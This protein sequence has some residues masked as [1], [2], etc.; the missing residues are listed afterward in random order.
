[1]PKKD[2]GMLKSLT[3]AEELGIAE[4]MQF[5]KGNG[6]ISFEEDYFESTLPEGMTMA[7]V[8]GVQKHSAALMAATT[9]AVG[10]Q[11]AEAFEGDPDLSEVTASYKVGGDRVQ[12]V[13]TRPTEENKGIA[14]VRN[15]VDV[16]GA[17]DRGELK[18]ARKFVGDLFSNLK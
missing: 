11:A 14:P 12:V 15:I 9:V 6:V 1:M 13:M 17:G 16:Y 5:D 3:M 7:M 10:T 2:E 18:K 4:K 8:K